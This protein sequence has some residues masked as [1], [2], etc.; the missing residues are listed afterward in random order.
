MRNFFIYGT[1]LLFTITS[2]SVQRFLPEGERIYKGATIKIEKKP[3]VKY[4]SHA[5]KRELK[6][7]V[8]PKANKFLFGQPYK[9]WFW[10]VIGGPKKVSGLKTFFR[11]KLSEPPVL[12][13][14]VNTTVIAKNM[15]SFLENKGYFRSQ[16]SGDTVN[17]SYFTKAIYKVDVHPQY[18]IKTIGWLNDTSTLAKELKERQRNGILKVGNGY[19]LSDVEA[20]RDRLDAY[21]KTKGYYYFNA[22]YIVAYVDSTVGNNQVDIILGLKNEI[23]EKSM[24]AYTI[25]E[26]GIF[27]DYTLLLPP[28]DTSA[29][30]AESVD[31]LFIRDTL[32]QFKPALFKKMITYRPGQTYSSNEQNNTLNR[33]INLGTFKFVKNTFE[34][35]GLSDDPYR[36][37]AFYYLT[38]AKKKSVQVQLNGF[39]KEN[40]FLGTQLS[41]NW[42]NRNVFKGA[43]QL[44]VKLYGGFEI[45][46]ADSIQNAK[47]IRVGVEAA[48]NFPKFKVPFLRYKESML[49]PPRTRLLAGYEIFRK[50][51][52]YTKNIYRLQYEFNWKVNPNT[53]HTLS[54]IALTYIHSGKLTDM[55]SKQANIDPV[56]LANVYNEIILGSYYS[57]TYN[58]ANPF[59]KNQW[60][61]S[62]S[63]D[64]SGNIA[65]LISGAKQPR[66]KKVFNTPFAQFS[67]FDV[68]LRYQKTL[69][70]KF[71]LVNRLQLGIGIPYSNSNMLPFSK[72]Y[73]IGGSSSL[74]GF[75]S[76]QLGP[77]AYQPTLYDQ[78]YFQ[79]IGGDYKFL[80]NSE[81]RMPV[82]G[83]LS[84][85]VFVDVGNIWT[86]DTL[87][88]GKAGKLKKDSYKELAVAT[89]AGLR[90][91]ASILLI[92]VD[93]GIPIRKPY[94]PEGHRWVFD[95]I[96]PGD[97][98]WRKQNLI[99]NIA[100]GY[101]F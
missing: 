68:D 1:F 15:Q 26:I 61:V 80:F 49:Y 21:V 82:F 66:Q 38:P 97:G 35:A 2:C 100:I 27:P 51:D 10:Y 11:K 39:S 75:T 50:L 48:L 78:R 65:G 96:A 18:T 74:R 98:E 33:L 76:R 29:T 57:Y 64:M 69:P 17:E 46:F 23:P 3:G 62:G 7:A 85:A 59:A 95:K 53:E 55:F 84:S 9:V 30:G 31:G 70:N 88:F 36:L 41:L 93:L 34:V 72:Q 81:L 99:V 67:K 87:L 42:K 79:A 24:H 44:S 37:N 91:D 92:R 40:K 101:P 4:G 47:N 20:E 45:S 19:R 83:K 12:S 28:P 32:H 52:F 54:P 60:Y 22:D 77:G 6:L 56:L 90:F 14:T 86:K 43:E 13:S 63:I 5:L 16:V 71:D 94:L 89:G 8:K 58:T 73:V 25:N